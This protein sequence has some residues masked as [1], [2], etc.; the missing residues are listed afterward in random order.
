M[1]AASLRHF[2]ESVCFKSPWN[3]AVFWKLQHQ[4][5]MVLTW[6]DGYP[7]IP[8][9]GEPHRSLIGNCYS[10]NINDCGSRSHNGY[11]RAY[12][13]GLAMAE[14]S[15]TYHIAGEGV[16]GEVAS[17]GIPHWISSDSL[18]PAKLSFGFAAECPDEWILQFVAGIKTILLVPCIPYGVLQLG[19]METVPENMEMVTNLAEVFDAHVNLFK[20]YPSENSEFL[21][22]S[23]ISESVN[24]PSATTTNEVNEDDVAADIPILKDKKLSAA[25]PMTSLI[26]VQHPFQLSGQH[27]QNVPENGNERKIGKFVERM[28]NILENANEREI[29]IQHADMINLVKQ[30]AHAYSDDNGSGITENNFGRSCHAKG[31]DAFSYSSCNVGGVTISNEVDCYFDGNMLDPQ[32]LGA[33]C[34]DTILGNLSNSLSYPTECE[35]Y[36][37]LGSTIQNNIAGKSIYTENP[38]FNIEPSFGESNEWRLRENNDENLLEA[39]VASARGFSDDY[40]LHNMVGLESLYMPSGKPAPFHKRKN[41]STESA[42]VGDDTVTQ[43]TLTSASAG[44]DKYASTNCPHSASSF[45]CV[46]SAFNEGQHQTKVFSSM[47]CHKES[48]ASNTNKKR[49][50]SGDGHKPRPRDRQLIQD[51]LKELRQLV[52]NGAK[53]SIDGLLDKTIKHMLFLRNVTDQA[54]K[55]RYQAQ[56]EVAPDKS[57]QLPELKPSNQQ[58]TCWALELGSVD[59]IC[60]II[61]KDLEYPGHMLIEMM[62]DDHGRF[63]EISD[64]IHRLELTI[65]KG[66]MEIRSE[67][68][69]AH[70]IVEASGSFHRLDI[71]WPLMQLLQQVPSSV[72][73]N[74]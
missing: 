57:L 74:M 52:P 54:D 48:K 29:G 14:M 73:R 67:S 45:D 71:F 61:V 68:T 3:Y 4:F 13:I 25:Y 43:S 35:L 30:L 70:F 69:W 46:V 33:D 62:C 63:L 47:S 65:L 16:V 55:L 64:V 49:G 38:M 9:A 66:V 8:C 50:R 42:S 72:S 56:K 26:E 37:A 11:L 5:P 19:S 53:C 34:S 10:K 2:L 17:L 40:S 32:S 24:I 23:T 51:R 44:A 36:E 58:G 12:P 28:P 60:P 15:S 21:L 27:M 41:P 22:Q 59:Q 1:S 39:V 6:Q 31:V 20:S 7:D 18:A